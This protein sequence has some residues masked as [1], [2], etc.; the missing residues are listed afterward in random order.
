MTTSVAERA[1]WEAVY[2]AKPP[3]ALSWYA[4]RLDASLAL[5]ECAAPDRGAAILDAGGG[6]S[7][8]VDDLLARGYR[9]LTVL[10]LSSAALAA[11]RLRLGAAAA[12]VRWLQA[13]LT[14]APFAPRAFD[15]WHDRAVFHFLASASA[16]RAYVE[17]LMRALKPGGE[18]ILAT[19]A[20]EGPPRCS[21]LPVARY[22]AAALA[23][24]LGAGFRLL[25]A[26]TALH[27]TPTGARQPFL[28]CRFRAA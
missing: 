26:V 22:D 21:G 18:L 8:L 10:D 17:H 28:Y 2:A 24:E 3:A 6:A 13:D 19:F 11:A 12:R 15:L 9:G 14:R 25:Q 16:R 4:P 23:R 7:T 20:P 5:I 27:H 1:H